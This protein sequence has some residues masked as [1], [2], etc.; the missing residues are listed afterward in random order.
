MTNFPTGSQGQLLKTKSNGSELL[1]V[2]P[3]HLFGLQLLDCQDF[4]CLVLLTAWIELPE[5]GNSNLEVLE[6]YSGKARISKFCSRM[7]LAARAFD[8]G[9][10]Q[11]TD[12]TSSF[13][14]RP[15]RSFMDMN[16]CP[17]FLFLA[18]HFKMSNMCWP[19]DSTIAC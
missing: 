7:G 6:F 4:I 14:G 1:V 12:A 18:C 11:P 9:Y 10:D 15:K 19:F 13:N 3:V 5:M 8:I 16:S 2:S 17:G